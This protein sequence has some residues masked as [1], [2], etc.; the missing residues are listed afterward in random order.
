MRRLHV[1]GAIGSAML[2]LAGAPAAAQ[3]ADC[4]NPQTQPNMTRCASIDYERADHEL[5]DVWSEAVAMARENDMLG[6]DDGKPG[7]E[8]T[9]R[10]AQRAWISF[11]DAN[12]EYEGFAARGGTMEP[13]LVFLCL[14]RVTSTR[15]NELRQ[16]IQ[17]M[18]TQ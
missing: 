18:G 3:E 17:E 8:E 15:T 14:A 6:T 10:K 16:L 7:Y 9:L 12:C 2:A 11:R 4:D 1:L 13:M 5:N